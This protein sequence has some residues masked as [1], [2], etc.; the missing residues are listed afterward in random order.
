MVNNWG[1]ARANT[2]GARAGAG[3]KKGWR[4]HYKPEAECQSHI[5]WMRLSDPLYIIW[6]DLGGIKWLRKF[7]SQQGKGK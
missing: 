1:G 2:G 6:E 4:G 5:V 7:L 3:R